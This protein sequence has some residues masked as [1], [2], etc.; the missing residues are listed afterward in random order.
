[1]IYTPISVLKVLSLQFFRDFFFK[2][3]YKLNE[4]K[5]RK[6]KKGGPRKEKKKP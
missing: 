6:S 4:H 1:M 5:R 3:I 2:K